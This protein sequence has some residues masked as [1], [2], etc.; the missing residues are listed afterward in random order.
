MLIKSYLFPS[1]AKSKVERK[2]PSLVCSIFRCLSKCLLSHSD[3]SIIDSEEYTN[4][5]TSTA[6]PSRAEL[7]LSVFLPGQKEKCV[8]RTRERPLLLQ[9]HN[10]N[11]KELYCRNFLGD[12]A[13]AHI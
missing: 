2:L 8:F 3:I 9:N 13:S 1:P 11:P 10:Q 4:R 5:S 12:E 7:T 6:V